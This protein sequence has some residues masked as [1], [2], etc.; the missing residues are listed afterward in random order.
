M[1]NRAAKRF[2][3]ELAKSTARSA[4]GDPS[5]ATIMVFTGQHLGLAD[6][7][8]PLSAAGDL[9]WIRVLN[10]GLGYLTGV[11]PSSS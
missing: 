9:S 8:S 7:T 1:V 2:A 11:F 4:P 3:N 10:A 6:G 5:V